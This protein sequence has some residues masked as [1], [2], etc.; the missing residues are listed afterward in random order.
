MYN[1]TL[2]SLEL[3][4]VVMPLTSAFVHFQLTSKF[5]K[6]LH[7]KYYLFPTLEIK[8]TKII[9]LDNKTNAFDFFSH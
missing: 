3:F 6:S 1:H 4:S 7:S 8:K 2:L 5:N 9:T